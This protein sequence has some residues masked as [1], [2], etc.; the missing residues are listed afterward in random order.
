LTSRYD[1]A[2]AGA[3]P[4]GAFCARL[5]AEAGL[6]VALV[7]NPPGRRRIEGASARTLALLAE[8]GLRPRGLLGHG[9]RRA[10]WPGFAAAV[11]DEALLERRAFD[12][13]L[14]ADAVAAGVRWFGGPVQGWRDGAWWIDGMPL[15]ARVLVDARG[16]RAPV[17]LERRRAPLAVAVS[18]AWHVAVDRAA[19]RVPTG[20]RTTATPDG[21][22]WRAAW[23]NGARWTQIV[24][25]GR[26]LAGGQRAVPALWHRFF[27]QPEAGGTDPL[28]RRWLARAAAIHHNPFDLQAG[29]P[30]RLG[31]A[32]V[33]LDPLSGHGIFWAL[34]SARMAPPLVRALLEGEVGL[35]QAFA[36]RR[37]ADTFRRQARIGRDFHRTAAA[38]LAGPYWQERAAW[39]D[40]EPAHTMAGAARIASRVIVRDGRLV[41]DEVLLT[42]QEPEGVAFVRD[43]PVVPIARRLLEDPGVD[44]LRIVAGMQPSLDSGAREFLIRWLESRGVI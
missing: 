23:G 2:I 14:T 29:E 27:A 10:D 40:D 5:L 9:P 35:A 16:R 12:A 26:R 1:V 39:P 22:V 21:W 24:V 19:E 3:G 33:A 42:P 44:P 32:A 37:F 7:G 15:P 25:D 38:T 13:G 30:L 36:A 6:S 11:G 41:A 28:P 31:D 43:V 17:A 4:A 20:T 34:A 8:A 18:G